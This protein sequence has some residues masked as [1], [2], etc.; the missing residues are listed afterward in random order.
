[1]I[2]SDKGIA[3][4][5]LS[6]LLD[7]AICSAY[8]D[9]FPHHAALASERAGLYFLR[10]EEEKLASKYLSRALI[11]YEEWGAVAK[12]R[13]LESGYET[14]LDSDPAQVRNLKKSNSIQPGTLMFTDRK[15]DPAPRQ[16]AQR[17]ASTGSTPQDFPTG[18][19]HTRSPGAGNTRSLSS[20]SR[21]KLMMKRRMSNSGTETAVQNTQSLHTRGRPVPSKT[22]K[23]DGGPRSK[24]VSQ[25]RRPSL[26]LLVRVGSSSSI[27]SNISNVSD[28][29][30]NTRR[31]TRKKNSS[32]NR[33][34]SKEKGKLFGRKKSSSPKPAE[35][36][37]EYNGPVPSPKPRK[38]KSVTE[39]EKPPSYL[40]NYDT[41]D[42]NTVNGDSDASFTPADKKSDRE[43]RR[44]G[45]R[46][47]LKT[48]EKPI[49]EIIGSDDKKGKEKTG[50]KTPKKKKKG[51]A[52]EK[53]AEGANDVLKTPKRKNK[54]LKSKT[55]TL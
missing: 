28:E 33:D 26:G 43:E 54:T 52:S 21:R 16:R 34:K 5:R 45:R 29:K 48:S 24:S 53:A 3:P 20:D 9:G 30:S 10:V 49:P 1:M 32:K 4:K 37:K 2:A 27:Q 6:I 25:R 41:D 14:L 39:V 19:R 47:S 31:G 40:F 7:T 44:A 35:E 8:Q 51:I 38:K 42:F 11:L 13:Q 55:L 22:A 50:K 12:V 18:S 46:A 23:E 17:R 36:K 15:S